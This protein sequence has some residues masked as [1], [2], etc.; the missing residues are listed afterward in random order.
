MSSCSIKDG[1]LWRVYC[2]VCGLQALRGPGLYSWQSR[3]PKRAGI[4]TLAQQA[5]GDRGCRLLRKLRQAAALCRAD[6][7]GWDQHHGQQEM[8]RPYY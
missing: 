7:D 2:I 5:A 1:Q 8:E 3:Q 6:T 4:S